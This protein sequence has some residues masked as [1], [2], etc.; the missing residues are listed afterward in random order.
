ML[1]LTD[2]VGR[3]AN[4]EGFGWK[5][6]GQGLEVSHRWRVLGGSGVSFIWFFGYVLYQIFLSYFL[7]CFALPGDSIVT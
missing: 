6:Y 2:F 1:N 5:V 4:L 3:G 7:A